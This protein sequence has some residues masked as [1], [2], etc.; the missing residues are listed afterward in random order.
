M[1]RDGIRARGRGRPV[2]D[3]VLTSREMV[4]ALVREWRDVGITARRRVNQRGGA[5]P[6]LVAAVGEEKFR[7][8]FLVGEQPVV[9]AGLGIALSTTGE[10]KD[11]GRIEER[12][13][14][15]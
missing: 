11:V 6:I 4:D 10:R 1:D 2:H 8:M 12:R 5:A 15:V 9:R 3:E 7:Q 13:V 14:A